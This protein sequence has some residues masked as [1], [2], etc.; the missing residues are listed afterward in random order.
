MLKNFKKEFLVF[1]GK[2][3]LSCLFPGFIFCMLILSKLVSIPHLPRYDFLLIA[4]VVMQLF[5]Y[6]TKLETATEL[7]VI[8]LFHLLGLAMEIFKV[9]KGSWFYPE[10]AYSKVYD[11]P[12]YSGF[13]YARHGGGSTCVLSIGQVSYLQG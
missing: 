8:T 7:L 6:V 13:M 3:I 9:A 11:V 4:C 2:Q 12:L 10:A 5:M 1:G